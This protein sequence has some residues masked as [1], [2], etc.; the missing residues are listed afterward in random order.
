MTS[1]DGDASA[2]GSGGRDS[3]LVASVLKAVTLIEVL[4][5]NGAHMSLKELAN[6]TG[7][8]VP[9]TYRLLSTL[10]EA[11]WVQHDSAGYRLSLRMVEL[12]GGVLSGVS[13]RTAARPILQRL[14]ATVGETSYLALYDYDHVLCL[15]RIESD[16][17]V[18]LM[19]WDVGQSLPLNRGGASLAIL[20]HL[21]A[22][23]LDEL[24]SLVHDP[25]VQGLQERLERIRHE[26]FALSAEEVTPGVASVGAAVFDSDGAVVAAISVGGLAPAIRQ[27]VPLLGAAVRG[28]AAELSRALG[29]TAR[30][31]GRPSTDPPDHSR[32]SLTS[33]QGSTG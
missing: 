25:V 11:D 3:A 15:E 4:A 31:S 28:A 22:T 20:A 33:T 8:P 24:P 27:K 13:I 17:I 10:E 30:P 12:A 32:R 5:A 29:Y 23:L 18:R 2:A 6:G 9:S 14:T 1:R 16:N 19:T 7:Q 21:P 26:G